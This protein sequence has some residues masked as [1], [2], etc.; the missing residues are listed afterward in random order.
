MK[1]ILLVLVIIF[2]SIFSDQSVCY[3]LD[4]QPSLSN[5]L[6][7]LM[8]GDLKEASRIANKFD[9]S[10]I[11]N[12]G[13]SFVLG[14]VNYK[15]NK[16]DN[17]VKYLESAAGIKHIQDYQKY[18]LGL[19]CLKISN[20]ECAIKSFK[21][22]INN[23]KDSCWLA[24]AKWELAKSYF[25][26]GE[27][28]ESLNALKN[29]SYGP[30]V[31]ESDYKIFKSDIFLALD[32]KDSA[33]N[34][35]REVYF[36]GESRFYMDEAVKKLKE[37]KIDGAQNI[38]NGLSTDESKLQAA[39]SLIQRFNFEEAINVLDTIKPKKNDL[40]TMDLV[41]DLYFRARNYKK[42]AE[43]YKK[44]I[45]KGRKSSHYM[46]RLAQSSARV[47]DFKEAISTYKKLISGIESGVEQRKYRYKLGFLYMDSKQYDTAVQVF[48]ELIDPTHR[49]YLKNEIVWNLAWCYYKL[50]LYEDAITHFQILEGL[51]NTKDL[52]FKVYYWLANAYDKN[53]MKNRAQIYY[54][55][56]IDQDMF[57]YYGFRAVMKT[58]GRLVIPDRWR[59]YGKALNPVASGLD[60]IQSLQK[61]E[62][63][64][65]LG[66][67]QFAEG[68]INSINTNQV[69]V[70]DAYAFIKF[71]TENSAYR[72]AFAVA[73]RNCKNM[74]SKF[75]SLKDFRRFVWSVVYPKAYDT[76]IKDNNKKYNIDPKLVFAMMREE[77]RFQETIVSNAGAIGLL[78]IIPPTARRL[79]K[80]L[81]YKDF[82]IKDLYKPDVNIR[83]SMQYLFDLSQMFNGEKIYMIAS[84]NAGED[85]VS[86]WKGASKDIPMEEFIEEIPYQETNNYVKKVLTSYWIYGRLYP[87]E[88]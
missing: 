7:Y 67:K 40:H 14:Y 63:L 37:I 18:F 81:K 10:L 84:Y 85:A 80:E 5:V 68:E 13:T 86:R 48:S 22:L 42:S 24:S 51:S 26:K 6:L 31:T 34:I 33:A 19:S 65:E 50:G 43:I 74:L 59:I 55:R 82:Q 28:Q 70:K 2:L 41:A 79:A 3:G 49:G 45:S 20:F 76:F 25:G 9:K 69:M 47:N 58:E 36:L 72:S 87:G 38:V 66:F 15:L 8:K 88:S 46:V 12:E 30:E 57:G 73:M 39:E 27:Y 29:I 53:G 17:A 56:L 62:Y 83:F 35:L 60:N 21:D 54:T 64:F 61:A 32:D 16:Y 75:T 23:Y 52:K 1:I 78:Q 77:S 71:A 11:D 44:L 4:G